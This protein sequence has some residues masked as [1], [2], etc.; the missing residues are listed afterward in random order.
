M[1]V[2]Q[3]VVRNTSHADSF[4][5]SITGAI[6]LAIGTGPPLPLLYSPVVVPGLQTS[7]R[8]LTFRAP[9]ADPDLDNAVLL[10]GEDPLA[11]RLPLSSTASATGTLPISFPTDARAR[12]GGLVFRARVI[13]VLRWKCVDSSAY[14]HGRTGRSDFTIAEPS[15]SSFHIQGEFVMGSA[16]ARA[17]TS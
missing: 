4:D 5:P 8:E 14:G 6:S 3:A 12:A 9:A 11:W 7:D 10:L 13:S 17:A 1:I 16:I 15:R 2:L